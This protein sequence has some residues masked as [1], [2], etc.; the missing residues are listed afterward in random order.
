MVRSATAAISAMADP[1]D[2][3]RLWSNVERWQEWNDQIVHAELLGPFAAGSKARIRFRGR[4]L[5]LTFQITA[6]VPERL[7]TDET[8]LP[9]AVLGHD[10]ILESDGDNTIIRH[11]LYLR[12]RAARL[13]W[14]LMGRQMRAAVGQFTEREREL[15]ESSASSHSQP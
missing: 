11:R 2:V 5:P 6:I 13:Y 10:H 15:L 1:A 4:P 9:G 7:F 14:L 12:G 8:R 3:W